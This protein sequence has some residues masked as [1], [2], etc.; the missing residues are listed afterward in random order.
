MNPGSEEILENP[1]LT[2]AVGRSP[3]SPRGGPYAV[4]IVGYET[5]QFPLRFFR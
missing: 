3:S 5:R 4:K 1:G 2:F